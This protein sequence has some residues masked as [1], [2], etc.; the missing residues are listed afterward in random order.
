[1]QSPK[2]D[3]RGFREISESRTTAFAI[4]LAIRRVTSDRLRDFTVEQMRRVQ[5]LSRIE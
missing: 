5:R 1:M 4:D 3:R 2:P